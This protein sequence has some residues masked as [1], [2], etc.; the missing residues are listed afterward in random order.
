MLLV[1]LGA[2][3]SYDSIGPL[4]HNANYPDKTRPPLAGELFDD[5]DLFRDVASKYGPAS[6]LF[7]TLRHAG[8]HGSIEAALSELQSEVSEHPSRIK[9]LA[10]L[11]FYIRDV[12]E[13]VCQQWTSGS[14]ES[15]LNHHALLEQLE[16]GRRDEPVLIVTFN[17]DPYVEYA[18]KRNGNAVGNLRAYIQDTHFP[19]F[20][21]HGSANWSREVTLSGL[22]DHR[23]LQNGGLDASGLI[24][25]AA[26]WREGDTFIANHTTYSEGRH[27]V[28]AIAIPVQSKSA[29]QC[30]GYHLSRL[31]EMLPQVDRI[32]T[33]G[34]RAQ[35]EHFL[36][37]LAEHATNPVRLFI[38]SGNSKA[39]E[40][41]ETHLRRAR[42]LVESAEATD[43]GFTDLVARNA[44]RHFMRA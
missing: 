7:P 11:R 18:L 41:T 21:L 34:W 23:D 10:A 22:I 17:Y 40:E 5:R 13:G 16:F 39:A 44:A 43:L 3:A 27:F 4:Q 33:V 25:Y 12:I 26:Q 29:F 19:L 32:L 14:R 30:P 24:K 38:V 42:L 1:I 2:G 15:Q 35:E 6:A 8:H 28:P 9:Q 36:R 20:K 31:R 37:L